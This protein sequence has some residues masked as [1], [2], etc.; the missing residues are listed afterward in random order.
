MYIAIDIGGTNTRI[1]SFDDI[2]PGSLLGYEKIRT[3][4]DYNEGLKDIENTIKNLAG[5][6]IVEAIGISIA[7]GIDINGRTAVNPNIPEWRAERIVPNL[8]EKF[9]TNIKII[10]DGSAGTLAESIIGA[11]KKYDA[12]T[13]LIWGTG[14]GGATIEKTKEKYSIYEYEPGHMPISGDGR[15]CRCGKINCIESYVGGKS[16]ENR[17]QKKMSEL[18]EEEWVEILNY[19]RAGINQILVKHPVE[20]II[21]DGKIILKHPGFVKK[22]ENAV[23]D[24]YPTWVKFEQSKI[25]DKAPLYGALLLLN[26]NIDIKFYKEF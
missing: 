26:K 6:N 25:G 23:D 20:N 10:N 7:S 8:K 12:F 17:Y 1:A 4:Q 18:K 13:F 15:K 9:S 2:N 5:H 3:H 19:M 24:D 11:G 22:L 16:V 14:L 21:F